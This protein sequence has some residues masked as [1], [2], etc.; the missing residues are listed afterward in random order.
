[1]TSGRCW[2][3]I[4][5][6]RL[7]RGS[8]CII[9]VLFLQRIKHNITFLTTKVQVAERAPGDAEGPFK[10]IYHCRRSQDAIN[11]LPAEFLDACSGIY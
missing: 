3:K 10:K 4:V 1:M 5:S 11:S 9:G 6:G 8:R 7:S 2:A